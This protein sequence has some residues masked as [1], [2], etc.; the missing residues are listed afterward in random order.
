MIT[1]PVELELEAELQWCSIC[2]R[3]LASVLVVDPAA[4]PI[5]GGGNEGTEFLVCKLC[6]EIA[7]PL[8]TT[9]YPSG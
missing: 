5:E 8:V 7:Q 3:A 1:V 6:A 9:P 2:E 4:S